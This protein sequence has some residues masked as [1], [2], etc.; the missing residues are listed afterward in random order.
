[1][2]IAGCRSG[3]CLELESKVVELERRS[4]KLM[5][6]GKWLK[7]EVYRNSEDPSQNGLIRFFINENRGEYKRFWAAPFIYNDTISLVQFDTIY[8]Q[9]FS[10][11]GYYSARN[12]KKNLSSSDYI[13]QPQINFPFGINIHS[14]HVEGDEHT[15]IHRNTFSSSSIA[16]YTIVNVSPI[17]PIDNQLLIDPRTNRPMSFDILVE[18]DDYEN[19]PT[20]LDNY[21]AMKIGIVEGQDVYSLSINHTHP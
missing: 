14:G 19:L 6:D 21:W 4:A 10:A 17:D 9:L 1:M 12:L 15:K 3:D 2:I 7:G 16:G 8:A 18:T 20:L 11:S 5:F 13:Y